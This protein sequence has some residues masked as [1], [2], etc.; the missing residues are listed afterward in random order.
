[1][2]L[3]FRQI[4]PFLKSPDPAVRAILVYGPDGGLVRERAKTLA[5]Q[6]ISDLSDPFNAAHLTGDAIES[7]PARLLDEANAR[8]LM[9]G[10]RLVR[11]TDPGEGIASS[12]KDWL[13]SNPGPETLIVIEAGDLKPK[14]ALRKLAEDAK[15]AAALPCYVEEERDLATFIRGAIQEAG[16]TIQ[17]DAAAWLAAN[18]RGDRQRARMEVE[19]LI[20]YCGGYGAENAASSSQQK[21]SITLE[22]AQNSSGEAGGQNLDDLIYA[23]MAGRA[24]QAMT[25]L[26]RMLSE[27]IEPIVLLRSLQNHLARLHLART[28]MDLHGQSALEAMKSLNPPIFFK[29]EDAFKA[30]LQRFSAP[31]LRGLLR[32]IALL[33]ARTKQT[34]VPVETLCAQTLLTLVKAA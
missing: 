17:S 23:V 3:Q 6:V 32:R 26:R 9:G 4:E 30:Q 27:G 29:Q 25:S 34:G 24:E 20:L 19:K 1:M 16:M 22:D 8:S 33:E 12:L 28:L 18:I 11:I 14:S 5:L 31:Q 13:K 2:K 15:N 7:D 21:K 10:R